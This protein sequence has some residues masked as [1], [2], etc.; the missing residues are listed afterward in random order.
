MV[1]GVSKEV[2][3]VTEITLKKQWLIRGKVRNKQVV[4]LRKEN[5]LRFNISMEQIILMDREQPQKKL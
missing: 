3:V 4:V 1:I 5:I 2:L